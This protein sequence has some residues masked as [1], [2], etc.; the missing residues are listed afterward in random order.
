M[1]EK[2]ILIS[3]VNGSELMRTLARFGVN[4]LGVR[5]MGGLQLAQLAL[6]RSGQAVTT[7]CLSPRE[8]PAFIYSFLQT[9]PYFAAAS[10]ADAEQLA[11]ALS[12]LR[13]QIP[14]GRSGRYSETG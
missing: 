6:M 14:A 4:C 2:I 1:K 8:A 5:F 11:A 3:A 13:R 12:A 7:P 9:I 10:Y